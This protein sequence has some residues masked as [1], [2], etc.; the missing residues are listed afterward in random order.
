MLPRRTGGNTI[1]PTCQAFAGVPESEGC[2]LPVCLPAV[3]MQPSLEQSSCPGG[4]RC[5]PCTDPLKGTST[6]AC[7]S[8]ACDAPALPP[9]TFE[10]CCDAGNGQNVGTCV[11]S[12][13]LPASQQSAL[14]QDSCSSGATLCVPDEYL[15][16]NSPTKC[17]ALGL[18]NGACVSR[19]VGS[20][21][22]KLLPA[23]TQCPPNDACVACG[24]APAG[25]PGCP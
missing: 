14:A 7:T 11:A 4:T 10:S 5:V 21:V 3:A 18:F 2:C 22:I 25:T 24:I 16:G 17:M 15:P 12:S 6:G 8:S 13:Q 9:Y 19:C 23:S 1:P 20:S